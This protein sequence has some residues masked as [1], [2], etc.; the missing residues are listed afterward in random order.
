MFA[1]TRPH[2]DP[3]YA[4]SAGKTNVLS[5]FFSVTANTDLLFAGGLEVCRP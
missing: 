2:I 1:Y 3:F 5:S 4:S